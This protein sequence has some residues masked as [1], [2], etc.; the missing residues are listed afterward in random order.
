MEPKFAHTDE[1]IQACFPVMVELHPHLERE[2]FVR[3][4][5]S[6]QAGGYSTSW[7]TLKK[8]ANPLPWLD[9]G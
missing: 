9:S 8:A 2:E 3:R 6:Q 1:E 4:V 5:R 7:S